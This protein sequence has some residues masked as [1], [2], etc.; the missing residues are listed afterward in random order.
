VTNGLEILC[1]PHARL[2]E[3]ILELSRASGLQ[4]HSA[5]AAERP[6]CAGILNGDET[7]A[8]RTRTIAA[9]L[10]IEAE[11]AQVTYQECEQFLSRAGPALVRL[12]TSEGPAFLA[13]VSGQKQWLT[14]LGPE[15]SK[16]RVRLDDVREAVCAGIG[17]EQ[18]AA[19]DRL[20][21]L[22][23]I[24]DLAKSQQ[25]RIRRVLL[26]E[27]IGT[28]PID[29]IWL[30]RLPP[31]APFFSQVRQ[32]GLLKPA[33]ALAGVYSGQYLLGLIAWWL[34]GAA[35]LEGHLDRGWLAAWALL[36]LTMLPL[37]ALATWYQGTFSI[38]VGGLLKRRL[39][40]GAL[41]LEPEEVR[42]QGAGQ[43]LGQ[44]IESEAVETLALSGGFIGLLAVFEVLIAIVVMALGAGGWFQVL[45][46]LGWI[47]ISLQLGWIAYRRNSSWTATRLR[48]THDLVEKMVGHR[49]RLAQ[50]RADR[51]HENEDPALEKYFGAS[52]AMDRS[53]TLLSALVPHGWMILGVLGLAPAFMAADRSQASL[54]V[55][56][57]GM[58][59]ASGA[60]QK[61]SMGF[62]SVA[63]AS[64]AWSQAAPLFH[65]AARSEVVGEPA[66]MPALSFRTA[67][68]QSPLIEA[69][70]LTFSHRRRMGA[71]L[72]GASLRICDG[73]RVLLQGESGS[74]KSTLASILAGLRV[75]D[76]GL[77]LLRGL[78]RDT[79][80][81]DSWRKSVAIVPQF[82][83]NHILTGTLA[84]N[85]LMGRRWP[86]R[87]EDL[88]QAETVCRELG[89][90]EL[91]D[92]MPAGL[93]QIVGENGWQLSHGERS[94][95]FIA[96]AL[97]QDSDL[98]ILDES[99]A[100][101]DPQNCLRIL[102][103]A[104]ARAN[105]ILVIAHP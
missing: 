80:G 90:G 6:D 84:F 70:D 99:F 72:N 73:D 40:F 49:T 96:R 98:V 77:I 68:P 83:E 56:L 85:V 27:Q 91:L 55:G 59:L 82:H 95:I 3:A 79:L 35:I 32:F 21:Q 89:L 30:L 81:L 69:H 29:G 44:V 9:R 75:Q 24:D 11:P 7:F 92:R 58:L 13:I 2:G 23:G 86:L 47:L 57:G 5:C 62:S 74:G 36:M 15:R 65:A 37:Q 16:R 4:R 22:A 61:L 46:F 43:L 93:F 48:L 1:W 78:D 53:G 38:G 60:L 71:V 67:E 39:L 50:E 102:R 105:A 42:G 10:G 34:V 33:G 31:G 87:P 45:L 103:C 52:E 25:T 26:R 28:A 14:L 8:A 101:L 17:A 88:E 104:S 63:G 97:L 41:R 20:I 66:F 64:I 76:S 12:P 100:V 19:V 18:S 51:W 94:R 54:A